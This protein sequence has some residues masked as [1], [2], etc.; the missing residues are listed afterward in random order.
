MPVPEA[1]EENE[2]GLSKGGRSAWLCSG[3]QADRR[4]ARTCRVEPHN[5]DGLPF[6][7]Y[8]RR[9]QYRQW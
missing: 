7:K 9:R 6:G 2:P 1:P 3:N 8:W 4:C 5:S